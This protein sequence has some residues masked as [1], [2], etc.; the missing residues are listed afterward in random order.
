MAVA[1]RYLRQP[2][3]VSVVDIMTILQSSYSTAPQSLISPGPKFCRNEKGDFRPLRL[4]SHGTRI[5]AV[6]I[7]IL[8][9]PELS[10]RKCLRVRLTGNLAGGFNPWRDAFG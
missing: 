2:T 8:R 3:E 10:E 9:R 4:R 6:N 7:S 5:G 1:A